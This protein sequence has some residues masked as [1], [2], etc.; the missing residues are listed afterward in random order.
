MSAFYEVMGPDRSY[1]VESITKRFSQ[2]YPDLEIEKIKFIVDSNIP[3]EKTDF[4]SWRGWATFGLEPK[5]MN[6]IKK[7]IQEIGNTPVD[8]KIQ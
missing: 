4:G 3:S 7:K 6:P 5:I 2:Q 8:K 1:V